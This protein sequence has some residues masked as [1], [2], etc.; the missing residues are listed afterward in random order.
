VISLRIDPVRLKD[1]QNARRHLE[2]A[3]HHR[4]IGSVP[5]HVRRS[6]AAEQQ[7]KRIDQNGFARAG[8]PGEQVE[9][10]TEVSDRTVDH[11]IVFRAQF[12]QHEGL[13]RMTYREDSKP[14]AEASIST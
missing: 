7:R 9:P 14:P 12:Q 11:S 13:R 5:H 4:L 8:L 2:D 10:Q 1:R 3:S 6:L